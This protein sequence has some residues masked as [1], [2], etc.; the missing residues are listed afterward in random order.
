MDYYQPL[1]AEEKYHIVS[2][3]TGSEKLFT[4]PENY[5]F[6]LQRFD[7]Y[8]SPV[9]DVFAYALLPN[10]FHFLLQATDISCETVQLGQVVSNKLSNGFRLLLSE[11]AREFNIINSRTGSLFRQKTKAKNLSE[12]KD[13]NYPIMCFDYIHQNPVQSGLC[14]QIDEWVYS[15]APDYLKKRNGSICNQDLAFSLLEIP[16]DYFTR[17]DKPGFDNEIIKKLY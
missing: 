1:L 15:S 2:R 6:F 11:Y 5:R 13:H 16:N 3:A 4:E 9:A 10:H 17:F 7:K 8:I 14:Y 12:I